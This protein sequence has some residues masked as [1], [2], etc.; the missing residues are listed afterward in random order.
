MI[1]AGIVTVPVRTRSSPKKIDCGFI[2]E[3]GDKTAIIEVFTG[4]SFYDLFSRGDTKKFS[5]IF[6]KRETLDDYLLRLRYEYKAEGWTLH[7]LI[8]I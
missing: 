6:Q 7:D 2:A 8:R 3:R 4:P 1:R 5:V